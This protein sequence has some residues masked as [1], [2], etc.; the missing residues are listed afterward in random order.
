MELI[1]LEATVRQAVE[2]VVPAERISLLTVQSYTEAQ[3]DDIVLVHI[4]HP[5]LT[6]RADYH[7][8]GQTY[9]AVSKAL[10]KVGNNSIPIVR[11]SYD[12]DDDSEAPLPPSRRK[13]V[14]TP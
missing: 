3:G 1:D 9:G 14:S 5:D 6:F 12:I 4:H 11:H 13:K 8:R 2:S 10:R 7:V